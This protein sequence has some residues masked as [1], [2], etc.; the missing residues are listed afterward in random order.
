MK[1]K[2]APARRCPLGN[3]PPRVSYSAHEI[4]AFARGVELFNARRFFDAHEVWEEI[5]LPATGHEKRCLQA[6]IQIAAAFHHHSR[7]NVLG[8]ESLLRAGVA[9]LE[10]APRS[11]RGIH[12]EKICIH[13]RRWVA[14]LEKGSDVGERVPPRLERASRSRK[15]PARK[16]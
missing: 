15:A 13:A 8:T 16:L 10:R 3:E 7:G 6:L 4:E 11:F 2:S 1:S 9:K 12:A 14:A 5:W